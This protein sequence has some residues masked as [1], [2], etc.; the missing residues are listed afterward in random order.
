MQ[1]GGNNSNQ[2]QDGN[3]QAFAL[4]NNQAKKLRKLH[5]KYDDAIKKHNNLNIKRQNFNEIIGS[6]I[7][8]YLVLGTLCFFAI[9]FDFF[10]NSKT[11]YWMPKLID[12]KAPVVFFAFIFSVFDIGIAMFQSGVFANNDPVSIEKAKKTWRPILWALAGLKMVLFIVFTF[13]VT[14]NGS[15]TTL[16][17]TGLWIIFIGVVYTILDKSGEGIY[18][19]SKWLYFKFL[20]EIWYENPNNI[21]LKGNN[22]YQKVKNKCTSLGLVF[23]TFVQLNNLPGQNLQPYNI[24]RDN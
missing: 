17:E 12:T 3:L 22:L 11:L 6:K 14:N 20:E 5:S 10:V 4:F 7:D 19:L 13:V 23:N 9:V 2:T 21:R 15:N 16:I 24:K 18:Y 8:K 1:D